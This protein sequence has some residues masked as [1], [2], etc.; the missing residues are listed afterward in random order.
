MRSRTTLAMILLR[1]ALAP[2]TANGF[3]HSD[4]RCEKEL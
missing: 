4:S 1:A 2:A 3:V